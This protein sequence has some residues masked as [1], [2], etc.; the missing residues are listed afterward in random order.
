MTKSLIRPRL[1]K[2]SADTNSEETICEM[3]FEE[4]FE[5]EYEAKETLMK[6]RTE[7]KTNV[8]RTEA[9]TE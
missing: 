9:K 8:M 1:Y 3:P 7:A 6:V 4:T 2:S 5:E